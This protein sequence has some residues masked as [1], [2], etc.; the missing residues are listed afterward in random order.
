MCGPSLG[1]EGGTGTCWEEWTSKK[2][3]GW[4]V[5]VETTHLKKYDIKSELDDFF[6]K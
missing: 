3:V 1:R 6:Q 4:L 5:V 2:P